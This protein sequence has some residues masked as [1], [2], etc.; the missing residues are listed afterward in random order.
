MNMTFDAS[1]YNHAVEQKNRARD[2]PLAEIRE[3]VQEFV[4]RSAE[5]D[6]MHT[7]KELQ[8]GHSH[9]YRPRD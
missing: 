8:T 9:K 3:Y 5:G 6:D 2:N 1:T 4:P 7:H